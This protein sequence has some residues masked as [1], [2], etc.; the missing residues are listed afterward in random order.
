M[1]IKTFYGVPKIVYGSKLSGTTPFL[2]AAIE[3][4][5]IQKRSLDSLI[6][7]LRGQPFDFWVCAWREGVGG[8]EEV[9]KG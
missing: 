9:V 5:S 3:I 7:L 2:R 8:G 1:D 4:D 6:V